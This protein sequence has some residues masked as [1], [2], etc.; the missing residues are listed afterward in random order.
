MLEKYHVLQSVLI[1]AFLMGV[2]A[3]ATDSAE[4]DLTKQTFQAIEDCMTRSPGEWSVEWRQ[5]YLETIRKAIESHEDTEHYAVRLEILRTGFVPC[6][7]GL[8]KIK[9][10]FLFEVY[11]CR[12]RWYVEHLM[13]SRFPSIEERQKLRNQYTDIWD[14]A[15]SSLLEQFTFLDPNAVQKAKT[16]ELS[17]C[18][19]KIDTPLKPV[20]LHPLSTE[21]VL[22]IKQRWDKLSYARFDL[23]RK[24]NSNPKTPYKDDNSSISDTERHYQLTKKSLSQ[25]L[26]L[27]WMIVPQRPHYYLAA[28]ENQTK[29]LKRRQQS[30]LDAHSNQR[31]LEKE[32]S[33]QLLQVEHI[34]FLFNVLLETPLCFD[35]APSTIT[36]E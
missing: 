15:A 20:Y 26:G 4:P 14:Y 22:K 33:R 3:G 9:D 1:T 25:L 17:L 27:V 21:H 24:L 31:R 32:R 34:S 11:R 28:M 12:M 30:N 6:W 16:E 13:G 18:Y 35:K 7:E 29:E 23:W 8:T 5:K 10:E 19:G 36:R 2:V